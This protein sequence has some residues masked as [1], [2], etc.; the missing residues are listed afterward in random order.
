MAASF[1]RIK[2]WFGYGRRER[3]S[4]FILLLILVVVFLIRYIVPSRIVEVEEIYPLTVPGNNGI[5][6]SR[7]TEAANYLP[8]SG[9]TRFENNA[10]RKKININRCDSADLEK[11]PGIG[12]VLS[13]R[14]IKYR[15]LLG[16]FISV[17][18]L[19][20]VYGLRDSTFNIIQH[21]LIADSVAVK[22]I[23][24]NTAAYRELIRHPYIDRD[25][26]SAILRYRE[27]N[28]SIAGIS[29]LVASGIFSGEKA[30]RIGPY[31][32]F[33]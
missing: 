9:G 21:Y 10:A 6:S 18:Q 13:V 3:R 15:N 28:G 20:E 31:L 7:E 27:T 12:R 32:D 24:V 16:G 29:E 4:T 5:H 8:V 11:L 14:I 26:V 19:K 1:R 30:V 33:R 2:D 25:E 17:N 23:N 22:K